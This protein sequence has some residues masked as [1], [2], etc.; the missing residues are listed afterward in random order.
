MKQ[1]IETSDEIY[2]KSILKKIYI[3]HT[4]K[5]RHLHIHIH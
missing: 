2:V 3:L 1:L 4:R 5:Y